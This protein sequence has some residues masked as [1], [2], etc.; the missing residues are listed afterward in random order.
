MLLGNTFFV[1]VK[2]IFL[3]R[4]R[5]QHM[6]KI[7][8][9]LIIG[10]VAVSCCPGLPTTPSNGN[11]STAPSI[12]STTA[13]SPAIGSPTTGEILSSIN[14]RTAAS[15]IAKLQPL[16]NNSVSQFESYKSFADNVNDIISILKD[17]TK[18]DNIPTLDASLDGYK[19]FSNVVTKWAPLVGTYNKLVY[20][21]RNYN[22]SNQ[23]SVQEFYTSAATFGF[24][25]SIIYTAAFYSISYDSVGMIYRESG[26]QEL[27]FVCG[28]CVSVVLSDA[29]WFIR[30]ALVEGS[31]KAFESIVDCMQENSITPE[32]LGNITSCFANKIGLS[33][34]TAGSIVNGVGTLA[35]QAIGTVGNI[36]SSLGIKIS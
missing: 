19:K 25:T 31:S 26:M 32:N 17:K 1:V 29:H 14:I 3:Q 35:N 23:S 27:A 5:I 30:G 8:A 13:S 20:S 9:I 15:E 33:N 22:E 7:L 2:F 36:T 34:V 21:A 28:P 10:I 4:V 16:D 24:E 12:N 11:S 6:E 18:F